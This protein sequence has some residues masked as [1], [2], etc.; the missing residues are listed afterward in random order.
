MPSSSFIVPSCPS[1][2]VF[3]KDDFL[4]KEFEV[5]QFLARYAGSFGLETLRDDL[6]MYLQGKI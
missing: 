1:G 4:D 6:G 5:D 2:V 3:N